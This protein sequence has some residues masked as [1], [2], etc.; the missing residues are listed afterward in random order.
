MEQP[1]GLQEC[2]GA[3][4]A[5]MMKEY[6]GAKKEKTFDE[7]ANFRKCCVYPVSQGDQ[8]FWRNRRECWWKKLGLSSNLF[9]CFGS[10]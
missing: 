2:E 3:Q 8:I 5:G 4:D 7:N 9:I 10:G 6:K 1:A